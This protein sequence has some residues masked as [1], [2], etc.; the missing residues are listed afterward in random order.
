MKK[1]NHV[2]GP[3]PS[4]RLG[5]SLGVSPI[6]GKTC[7]YSCTYCQL[8]RTDRMSNQ[9]EWFYPVEEIIEELEV[10]LSDSDRF[11]VISIV[12]EGEPT[13]YSGLGQLIRQI[14][15][16]TDKPVAVITNG[17]LLWD[18]QV[19]DELAEA[20]LV[21][22]SLDSPNERVWKTVDRPVGHLSFDQIICGLEQF[23]HGFTGQIWVEIMLIAGKNDSDQDIEAFRKALSKI[24]HDRVYINTPVRPPAEEA[25]KCPSPERVQQV[26]EALSAISIDMLSTGG[27][28][29]EVEDH[30]EAVLSIIQRHPMNQ[31]EV[32]S[33]LLSREL[34]SDEVEGIIQDLKEDPS[35]EAVDYKGF[36]TFRLKQKK[37]ETR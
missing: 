6:P 14:K 2:F 35:V 3:I 19:R 17:A 23:S 29:S 13:L 4:R 9:R 25:V 26:V 12:G 7:N 21:L 27:F 8:G 20:D 37:V 24:R 32:A 22:P 10:Y 5:N 11:D 28:F 16:R 33:F 18:H 1:F 30:Y 15:A 31:F 34:P 36:T